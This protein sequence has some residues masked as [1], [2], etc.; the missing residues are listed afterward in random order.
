M[1]TVRGATHV[2]VR[3]L[4]PLPDRWF[5][6]RAWTTSGPKATTA[7]L[8]LW[9]AAAFG[10]SRLKAAPTCDFLSSVIVFRFLLFL[11]ILLPLLLSFRSGAE[12]RGHLL[13][14]GARVKASSEEAFTHPSTY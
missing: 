11:L 13:G 14:W 12:D 8:L 5:S 2:T 7:V 4:A 1:F 3:W 10:T 9:C 6:L